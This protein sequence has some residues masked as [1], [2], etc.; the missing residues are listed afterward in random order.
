MKNVVA[1]LRPSYRILMGTPDVIRA[2][3]AVA[4]VPK[5]LIY[6]GDRRRA[7]VL[8]GAPP[9]LHQQ[10][11]RAVRQATVAGKRLPKD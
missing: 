7:K 6:D 9:D 2:F 4:A 5:L 3:G 8:Y 1:A 11:D 10:I